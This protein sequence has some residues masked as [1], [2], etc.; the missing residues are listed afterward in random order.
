MTSNGTA[1]SQNGAG[2]QAS[3]APASSNASSGNKQ[4]DP[5]E[6]GWLFVPQYYLLLNQDPQRLHRFYTKRSTLIHGVEQEDT[7]PCFGQQAIHSKILSLDFQDCKVFV[8][9]V[10]SQSS[11][12]GGIVIQV[13]GEMSNK[14]GP[15]RKFAQTF[16]L[17]EQPNG[18]FVLNDIF[19]YLKDEEE[20]EEEVQEVDDAL[21]DELA[22]AEKKS[23]VV[24]HDVDVTVALQEGDKEYLPSADT[25]RA[26]LPVATQAE[27]SDEEPENQ[28]ASIAEQMASTDEPAPETQSAAPAANRVA[29]E[30]SPAPPASTSTAAAA[31]KSDSAPT[32]QS[33]SSAP[34]PA[35]PSAPKTW[36][37]LAASSANKWTENVASNARGITTAPKPSAPAARA[38]SAAPPAAPSATSRTSAPAATPGRPHRGD[39]EASV[40]VKNVNA[41][42][43]KT[44]ALQKVLSSF[45]NV[46]NLHMIPQKACAFADFATADDAKRA[47]S[48]SQEN[49]GISIDGWT[50]S[51]EEKRKHDKPAG[52][53]RGQSDRGSFHG[54]A[55][56]GRGRGN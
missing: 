53:G 28:Q 15:W 30:P 22:D 5:S 26:S 32:S 20:T 10:D 35:K 41:D 55:G 54:N 56:R 25:L 52:T 4:A 46:L 50:V 18:Y 34:A 21:N 3:A 36:A 31:K 38:P 43:V 37:S 2:A 11:A 51:V 9:S 16:F 47:I 40:F 1:H 13:L 7:T 48:A 44:E 23:G 19:R 49:G 42:R 39:E 17:A 24:H 29:A 6:V 27:Q 8:S 45:G 33:A 12:N 14:D